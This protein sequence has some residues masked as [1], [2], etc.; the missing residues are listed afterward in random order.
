MTTPRLELIQGGK[1]TDDGDSGGPR[2][3]DP[4]PAVMAE[5]AIY[6]TVGHLEKTKLIALSAATA[7]ENGNEIEATEILEKA[8]RES[9]EAYQR[10]DTA[11]QL[12]GVDTAAFFGGGE[13]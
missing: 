8:L 12:L 11:L 7:L 4:T 10:I 6:T 3:I 1:M 5:A 9:A 2:E 13:T